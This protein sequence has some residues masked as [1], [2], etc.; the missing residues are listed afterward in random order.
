[1]RIN[2]DSLLQFNMLG[3]VMCATLHD[4]TPVKKGETVAATRLIPLISTRRLIAEA[5][6]I[7]VSGTPVVEVLALNR[8]KSA[9]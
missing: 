3:E 2:K 1:M 4:N 6:K 8:S 5:E 7:A 9:W